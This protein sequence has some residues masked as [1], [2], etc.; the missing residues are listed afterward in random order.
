MADEIKIEFEL[1]YS[2]SV[3]GVSGL[4][5][6]EQDVLAD[7][8]GLYESGTMLLQ[9]GEEEIEPDRD[10]SSIGYVYI[11]N[12][13]ENS[14]IIGRVGEGTILIKP[15]EIAIFRANGDIYGRSQTATTY[16]EYIM[17]ED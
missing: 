3:P 10:L 11:K 6:S 13:G 7:C 9:T 16:I 2:P 15:G 17:F 8:S 1:L 14:C 12:I 4:S 5:V